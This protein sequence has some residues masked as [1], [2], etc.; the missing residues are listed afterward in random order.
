MLLR[1][2]YWKTLKVSRL[3]GIR[4]LATGSNSAVW[5][6]WAEEEASPSSEKHDDNIDEMEA[7]GG[8]N[9]YAN[10][11][12]LLEDDLNTERDVERLINSLKKMDEGASVLGSGLVKDHGHKLN[13]SEMESP[14]DTTSRPLNR[15]RNIIYDEGELDNSNLDLPP[16][17]TNP[18]PFDEKWQKLSLP[19]THARSMAAYVNH[20]KVL[21]NLLDLGVDLLDIDTK[22]TLAR[23]FVR[24]DWEKDA[25]P[26][27]NWLVKSIGV[28]HEMLANYI[29]RNPFFLIQNLD[30][31]KERV[32]YLKSKKFTKAQIIKIVT[33]N[34]YWLNMD[35]KTTDSRLG[36][37]QRQFKLSGN[38]VRYLI[39]KEPRLFVFGLGPLQRLVLLLNNE[40]RFTEQDIKKMLLED[41]R[42]FMIEAK[43]IVLSFNYLAIKMDI[44]NYLIVDY[45]CSLR[46]SVAAIRKRHEFLKRLNKAI[47]NPE[48]PGCVSLQNLLQPSDRKFA[49]NVARVKL[50]DYNT[51]LKIL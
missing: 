30:E 36:W 21:Q 23:H 49:E 48:L 28:D 12:D 46:C 40:L 27:L 22:T 32:S 18:H 41:P 45:P 19:P 33:E 47:Y 44:P 39:T 16:S 5:K 51:F 35:V 29:T 9:A 20:S 43:H 31:M 50:E 1:S 15:W 26:R 10:E 13:V 14:D 6:Q 37:L 11:K 17:E 3:V 2:L 4:K 8:I 24:M 7:F 34:R 42:L 38:E 25:F